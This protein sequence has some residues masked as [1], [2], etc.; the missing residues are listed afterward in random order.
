VSVRSLRRLTAAAALVLATLCG[1]Y[2][3]MGTPQYSFS[4]FAR[5]IHDRDAAAAERFVD[6][7]RVAGAASDLIVSDYLVGSPKAVEA[8][9]ALGPGVA[10]GA[11]QAVKP[12]VAARLRREIR[13]MAAAGGQDPAIL[14]L[15]VG[16]FAVFSK[17]TVTREGADAWLT[18]PEARGGQTRL[19]MSQRSDRS[20]QITEIDREWVRRHLKDG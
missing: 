9:D 1:W 12:L 4:R 18:Y 19:R 11:G 8:L 7:D 2:F 14:V 10:H 20:W 17:V 13:R 3:L 6:V 15:P 16:V 5:A